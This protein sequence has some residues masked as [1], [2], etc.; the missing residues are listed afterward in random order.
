MLHIALP[1]VRWLGYDFQDVWYPPAGRDHHQR[2]ACDPKSIGTCNQGKH[3]LV[4]PIQRLFCP[5]V[6]VEQID[7]AFVENI[8]MK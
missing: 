8:H 2:L 3:L 1:P 7:N 4:P 5:F 6:I